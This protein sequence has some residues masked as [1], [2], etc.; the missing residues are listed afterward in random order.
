MGLPRVNVLGVGITAA[1]LGQAADEIESWIDQ[2]RRFYVNVCTVHTV[3]ECRRAS[4]LRAIVNAGGM[5]TADGMP[6]VWL[7][8]WY[9]HRHAGRVY[10]PDLFLELCRR[11][12]EKGYRHFLYGGSPP[13]VAQLAERL[14]ARFP[15]LEIVGTHSPPFRP[16]DAAEDEQVLAKI[17]AARPDVVWVGLGTPKQ[18][19]WI[20]RHRPL[21]AAPV[22]IAVGAAFDFHAGRLAQAP[23]WMQRS[24]LEW[25]FRLAHEPRRLAR[26]YLVYNPLFVLEVALQL[27]GLRQFQ[28][29]APP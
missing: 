4:R 17:E 25:L 18:D 15:R 2:R 26:R 10:G 12:E 27:I 1:N 14:R 20:A 13:V 23:P 11:S 5:A 29:D 22:L 9:G 16:A 8:R 7:A 24:G 21:L 28:C 19:Y 6:L 3:M